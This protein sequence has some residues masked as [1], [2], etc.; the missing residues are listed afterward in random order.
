VRIGILHSFYQSS[1]PSGENLVVQLQAEALANAGHEVRIIGR[2]SD[3]FLE[4]R[5]YALKAALTVATGRGPSPLREIEEFQPDIVH[6]HN[7][8]PNWSTSWVKEVGVPL[9][10]TVHNF[11]PVCAAG[12]LLRDGAYCELCPTRGSHHAIK[13]SCYRDSTIATIPLAIASRK[14]RTPVLFEHADALVF[15]SERSRETYLSLG[16]SFDEKFHVIPNFVN[17]PEPEASETAV[18]EAPYWIF[19]GRLSEEKGLLNLI[20]HWPTGY[21][22]EV[23]GSGP[24][25]E[26]CRRAAA[27]KEISFHGQQDRETVAELMSGAI[28][29]VFPSVWFESAPS[30]VYVEAL[31]LGLP[32]LALSGNTVADDVVEF[33]TGISVDSWEGIEDALQNIELNRL[34]LSRAADARFQQRFTQQVWS[35]EMLPLYE[36]LTRN[37]SCSA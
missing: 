4:D 7:L 3:D 26:E 14:S 34:E 12:T 5:M 27:G 24:Q 19:V 22:L 28:G 31:A 17:R 2:N 20:R 1:I 30:T 10:V 9:V 8:F 29:M 36:G 25:E 23:V 35:A 32:V 21:R 6:V 37:G 11:R 18:R 13:H 15:L 16:L 33:G